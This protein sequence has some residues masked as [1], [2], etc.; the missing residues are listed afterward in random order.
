MSVDQTPPDRPQASAQKIGDVLWALTLFA[1]L[2]EQGA[3]SIAPMPCAA[4]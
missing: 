2:Y 4:S 3:V 1:R